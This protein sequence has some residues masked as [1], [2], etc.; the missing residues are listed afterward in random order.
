MATTRK[1]THQE[2]QEHPDPDGGNVCGRRPRPG[3]GHRRVAHQGPHHPRA[4]CRRATGWRPRWATCATCPATPRRSRR[5]T[6]GEWARLG[7]NV[8]NDFEPLY[9]VPGRQEGGGQGAEGRAQ[10]RRRALPRHRRRPRG[11]EHLLAPARGAEAEGAG[12]SGWCSTRS[13]R[14]RSAR[15]STTPA[16]STMRPGAT[17]RRRAASSIA[18]WATPSRR[19]SGRR[20]PAASPPAGCSRWRCGCWW[21]ASASASRLPHRL[22]TGISSATARQRRCGASR[23]S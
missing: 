20:S 17:R 19:C 3:P 8:D 9:I 14:R 10:G 21:S 18:W 22:P 7:V 16:T 6:R 5:S 13:P 1:T 11:R 15:R 12:A 4:S 23:P 2:G